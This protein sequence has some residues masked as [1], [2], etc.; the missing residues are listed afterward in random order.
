L[1]LAQRHRATA[2]HLEQAQAGILS[3]NLS[4]ALAGSWMRIKPTRFYQARPFF[5][6]ARQF[7]YRGGSIFLSSETNFLSRRAIFVYD[8]IWIRI[9]Y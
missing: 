8:L 2:R 4:G 1:R 6:E 3:K 9:K 7:F 5:I